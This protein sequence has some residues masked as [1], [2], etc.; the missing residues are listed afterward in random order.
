MLVLRVVKALCLLVV[1]CIAAPLPAASA[2][3]AQSEFMIV[4]VDDL[5][6]PVAGQPVTFDTTL[7]TTDGAPIAAAQVTLDLQPY[8]AATPT[9]V[10]TTT[11]ASGHAVVTIPLVRTTSYRWTYVGDADFDSASSPTLVR[12]IAPRVTRHAHDRTLHRGQRLIVRGQTFPA[13]AGCRVV[14]LRGRVQPLIMGLRPVRLARATVRSDGSY[15]LVRR[16]HKKARMR[17]VVK[18]A[19]CA[20]NE[21]GYS[22]YLRLRVR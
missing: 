17:V 13:K 9:S 5:I 16:F 1:A 6:A 3:P 18:V 19:S 7:L 20:G 8:G 14:L 10:A 22:P 15:R 2:A 4:V 21:A 11:D 12:G